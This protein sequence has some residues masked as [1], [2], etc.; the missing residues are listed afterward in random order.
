MGKRKTGLSCFI[1][2]IL[3]AALLSA[4]FS[5]LG[6][7]AAQNSVVRVAYFDLSDYYTVQEDGSVDSY[8]AAYLS[9][10][11]EYTG[12]EFTYVECG[13]WDNA[14]KMMENHEIDLVGTMQWT[15][16]RED[17]YEICD[18]NYG[19]T[20]AE[21]AALPNSDFIYEDYQKMNGAT[22]GCIDGYVIYDKLQEL[23]EEHDIS[24]TI[25]PYS[26]Q[27]LLTQALEAGEIDLLAAN[28]HAMDA[29]WKIIEKF[30]YAPFYFASWK[31]NAKLT[32]KI[33]DAII[34]I[35]MHQDEF[36][37]NLIKEYFLQVVNS[38]YNKAEMDSVAKANTYT[39]YLDGN[40]KPLSSYDEETDSMQ[41]ILADVCKK[42][43]EK[44]GLIIELRP[45]EEK[46]EL[47]LAE[48]ICYY[49]YQREFDTTT[50]KKN[51]KTKSI[52]DEEFQLY[53][54]SG[55]PYLGDSGQSYRVAVPSGRKGCQDY[56][57][58]NF[59]RY[60]IVE[61]TTPD[62]CIHHLD[63]GDVELAFMSSYVAN[64]II[65]SEDISTLSAVPTSSVKFGIGLQF[66]GEE[67]EILADVVDKG[68]NLIESSE[69]QKII[70]SHVTYT[71]PKATLLYFFRHNLP[72][73]MLVVFVLFLLAILTVGL[74]IY[75]RIIKV[76]NKQIQEADQ[77]RMDFFSRMSHDMRTPMNGILGM[78]ELTE[79]ASDMDEVKK[80]MAKAKSAGSYMLSL[81]NDTLDLQRLENGRLQF[82]P[83]IVSIKE[84]VDN[85]SGMVIP[86]AEQ[87][88]ITMTLNAGEL[89]LDGYVRL[90]PVR[91]K[92]VFV[93]ILSNAIKFTP[94]GGSITVEV[95]RLGRDE[96]VTHNKISIR[97]TGI[98]MSEEFIKKNLYKPYSQEQNTMTN[99]Y[100][101]SGLGLAITKNLVDLMG[102][103]MEV[104]SK[105]G[106]GTTFSVYLD[107]TYVEADTVLESRQTRDR[108]QS[109]V[110]SALKD[111]HILICEDHPLNAEI[112]RRLLEKVGCVVI[113]AENGQAGVE[114]FSS[115]A[116]G[117]FDAI[118]MDIRMP[119][120]DGITA[121]KT[122]RKLN[123]ADAA[124][125]PI[126]AM[127]ANAYDSDVQ[128]S[129]EAGMNAHLAK[130][131]DPQTLYETIIDKINSNR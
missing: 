87:K 62:E 28:A 127:T 52:F 94:K 91:V 59:P 26:T 102:G 57:K 89:T 27:K 34:R 66:R 103:R 12:L 124:A 47:L 111:K 96:N 18:A 7:S 75:T 88:E 37:D 20:V 112:A 125:I 58:E 50:D 43:A 33:S 70:L 84:F 30:A 77:A 44:T 49:L 82:H 92:Q 69:I 51:G 2:G 129:K 48:D 64:D 17:K 126:I 38:P 110:Q 14:L 22:V 81:V 53:H 9:M 55:M 19:Y 36:D 11:A 63:S 113:I 39:I 35:N 74:L 98:G 15:Q 41:G 1:C 123:R 40:A 118:L 117:T 90:D 4:M 108:Q 116:E 25:K 73:F 109:L 54:K 24:F 6:V 114:R 45:M 119:V 99:M 83:Q 79:Q 115:A 61:Y 100:A 56:L 23:M 72:I 8:D 71:A 76:K 5:P 97:D 85:L 131:I 16:E 65:V 128:Q 95:E 101:G 32:E 46:S 105:V 10:I 80:N 121:A 42:I 29:S 106:E 67:A 31:G 3:S 122:I 93:N 107:F 60:E 130:P 68:Y 21:L 78:I 120:M 86:S 13:T 104:Q